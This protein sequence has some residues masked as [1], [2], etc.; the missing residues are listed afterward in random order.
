MELSEELWG[1]H[2]RQWTANSDPEA[3]RA[4]HPHDTE[5]RA[6]LPKHDQQGEK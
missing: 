5:R 3:G 4:G 1:E 2:P 6:V